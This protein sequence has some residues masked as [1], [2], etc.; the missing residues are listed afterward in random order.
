MAEGM[1]ADVTVTA[2]FPCLIY[3]A[4]VMKITRAPIGEKPIH[5]LGVPVFSEVGRLRA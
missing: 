1:F 2:L 5:R 4:N 3:K